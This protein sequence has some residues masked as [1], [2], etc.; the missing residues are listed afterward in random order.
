[1][2]N[3]DLYLDFPP[4]RPVPEGKKT[5]AACEGHGGYNVR[6]N[7]Y[8]LH[9]YENTR[10]NRHLHA[11]FRHGCVNCN[12]LGYVPEDQDCVHQWGERRTVGMSQHRYSCIN[13][14]SQWTVDSGD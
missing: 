13:C 9:R 7:A 2:I 1:M 4:V 10:E 3:E 8:P 12:G 5:C 14:G 6:L 11:H